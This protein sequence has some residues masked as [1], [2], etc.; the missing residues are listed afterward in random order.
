MT[1]TEIGKE[2]FGVTVA[3]VFTAAN[4]ALTLTLTGDT[5]TIGWHAVV[6]MNMVV[7]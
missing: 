7:G 2:G 6:K 4:D 1:L 3:P 5:T